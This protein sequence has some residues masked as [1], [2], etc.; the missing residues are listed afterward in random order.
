MMQTSPNL[1]PKPLY[2][3][4]THDFSWEYK[5]D[6]NNQ[7]IAV[8]RALEITYFPTWLADLVM[9]HLIDEVYENRKPKQNPELDREMIQ[10][11]V[12]ITDLDL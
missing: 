6:D 7:H 8:C 1:K 2:N 9:K 4:L 5:D 11:E 12:E 10:K 3:P